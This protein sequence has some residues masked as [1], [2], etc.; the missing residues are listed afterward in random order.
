MLASGGYPWTV[1][2]VEQ[3]ATYMHSLDQASVEQDISS[4]TSFLAN[5]VSETMRGNEVAK[6]PAI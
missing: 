2:P 5:L 1:I 6:L 4:F 3:R